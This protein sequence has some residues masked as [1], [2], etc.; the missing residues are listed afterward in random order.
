MYD[1]PLDNPLEEA[2]EGLREHEAR[3]VVEAVLLAASDPVEPGFLAQLVELPVARI[4]ELCRDLADEYEAT[5]RGFVLTRVAGGYRFQT[6][7]DMAPYVERFVLEGQ[8]ARLSAPAFETLAIVAYKQPISRAQISAIRGVDVES[9][10]GTLLRRGYVQEVG[11]DPGPGQAVMYGTTR[12]FLERLG[13][14]SLE[15][16]PPLGDFVPAPEVVDALE[17]GLRVSDDPSPNP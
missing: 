16:L 10:L 15:D 5:G 17:R 1:D 14:D 6:H 4:E 3:R 2:A 9:V 13:I 11:R 8:H 7:P 12:E